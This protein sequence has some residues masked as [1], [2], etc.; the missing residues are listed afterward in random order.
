M[1]YYK[2]GSNIIKDQALRFKEKSGFQV[3]INV[4]NCISL[5]GFSI[6]GLSSGLILMPIFAPIGIIYQLYKVV[7]LLVHGLCC[8]SGEIREDEHLSEFESP[9][10]KSPYHTLPAFQIAP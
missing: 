4:A 8:G 1:A 2:P 7:V 5:I 3:H 6:L 10:T 9:A